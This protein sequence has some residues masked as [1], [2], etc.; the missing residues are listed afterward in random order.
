MGDR[1]HDIQRG[2]AQG[3]PLSPVLTAAVMTIWSAMVEAGP[4]SGVESMSIVD[5][6]A[7]WCATLRRAFRDAKVRSNQFDAAYDLHCD[8]T[9]GPP[10]LL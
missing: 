6:R 2:V 10:R 7:M 4:S 8:H 1:W 5:D 3:C 9:K